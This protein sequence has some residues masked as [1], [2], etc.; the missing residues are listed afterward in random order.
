MVLK[1]RI[2]A[3]NDHIWRSIK[4]VDN[5]TDFLSNI[6]FKDITALLD[7]IFIN[8]EYR[9]NLSERKLLSMYEAAI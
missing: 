6:D 3:L 9:L 5:S 1:S 4:S 8:G 2:D 7:R